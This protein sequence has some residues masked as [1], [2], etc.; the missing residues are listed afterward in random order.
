M[1]VE[2]HITS[3]LNIN[4]S[5]E[6]IAIKYN[7]IH[8]FAQSDDIY[9]GISII[10]SNAYETVNKTELYLGRLL[11]VQCKSKITGE[12]TNIVGSYG[13]HSWAIKERNLIRK[14]KEA[15]T[16]HKFNV[17]L[18]DFN[19]VEDRLDRNAKN[20]TLKGQLKRRDKLTS[21]ARF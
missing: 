18:G 21:I 5:F 17:I 10:I 11:A 3:E 16:S 8:S 9:A 13:F 1:L 7:V 6:D 4:S 14:F 20:A 15:L 19:L 2:T 12:I